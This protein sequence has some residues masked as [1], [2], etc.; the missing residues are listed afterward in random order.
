M[1]PLSDD[2]RR[3]IL[4]AYA[5][6]EG[7]QAHLARR[8]QVSFEFVR[9]QFRQTEQMERMPQARHNAPSRMT[10]SAREGYVRTAPEAYS[11]VSLLPRL[12]DAAVAFTGSLHRK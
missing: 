3:R 11:D 2:L 4:E 6:E 9:K 5:R 12:L 10:A 8:F 1:P 7:S